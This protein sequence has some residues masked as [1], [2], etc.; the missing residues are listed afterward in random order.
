MS[1]F[2]LARY[3]VDPARADELQERW[4]AAV[5]AIR[6][7]VPGLVRANL[8]RL[9]DSTWVDVWEWESMDAATRAA[10]EA[11]SI[12]EAAAMFAV[13]AEPLAMEHVEIVERA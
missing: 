4:P 13:I 3:R 2:E 1:A 8:T 9:D 5:A 10:A 7:R 11:P 6:E 12:S